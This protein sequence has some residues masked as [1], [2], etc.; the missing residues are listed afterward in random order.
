MAKAYGRI[1]TGILFT[2]ININF[3][4]IDILPDFI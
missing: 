1:F 3:G 4:P 2:F